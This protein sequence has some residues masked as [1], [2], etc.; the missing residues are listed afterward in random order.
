MMCL[1]ALGQNV[2]L[3]FQLVY[4]SIFSSFHFTAEASKTGEYAVLE[5]QWKFSEGEEKS[6]PKPPE[7]QQKSARA[8]N[9]VFFSSSNKTP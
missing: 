8:V 7:G 4:F 3:L 2:F 9:A 1:T 6:Q 5:T